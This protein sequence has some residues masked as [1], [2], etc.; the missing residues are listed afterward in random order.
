MAHNTTWASDPFQRE[1]VVSYDLQQS[2]WGMAMVRA[3]GEGTSIITDTEVEE[4]DR[5]VQR[6]SQ[7]MAAEELTERVGTYFGD[8]W[9]P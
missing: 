6:E 3:L 9:F 2:A 7:R 4:T 1:P 5:Y 8:Y